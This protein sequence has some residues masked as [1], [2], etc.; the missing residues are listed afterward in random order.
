MILMKYHIIRLVEGVNSQWNKFSSFFV[1]CEVCCEQFLC[2]SG[3]FLVSFWWSYASTY[4]LHSS[5]TSLNTTTA[6]SSTSM[7]VTFGFGTF[8]VWLCH[9][10]DLDCLYMLPLTYGACILNIKIILSLSNVSDVLQGKL[11]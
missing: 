1:V 10:H 7:P 4:L 6:P 11:H 2:L 3:V 9:W 8:S 5:L